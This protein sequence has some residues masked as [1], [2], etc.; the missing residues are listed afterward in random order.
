VRRPADFRYQPRTGHR[1]SALAARISITSGCRTVHA[2]SYFK[3]VLGLERLNE[4]LLQLFHER[5]ITAIP[6]SS[7]FPRTRNSLRSRLSGS[8][9]EQV[10]ANRPVALLELILILEQKRR[11]QRGARDHDP[12]DPQK[13]ALIDDAFRQDK[14]ANRLFVEIFQ[15][16]RGLTHQLRR[17][18]R[19][20]ILAATCPPSR[21]SSPAC[22]TTCFISTRSMSIRCS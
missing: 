1:N 5:F 16:P 21:T 4:M 17:M 6:T 18:N 13:P 14:T 2:S 22:S 3:T 7:P 15:Q 10:F 19:Y 12:P 11:T 9:D 8:V 20:G